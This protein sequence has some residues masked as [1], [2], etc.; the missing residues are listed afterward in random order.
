MRPDTYKAA[1]FRGIG[2]VDVVNL[3]YPVCG[4]DDIVVR[5]LLTGVCGSD[6]S[7]Y[8]HGGDSHM[9]WKD[10]EFGHESLSEV[11]EIGK[12][13]RDLKIGDHVFPNQGKALRDSKRMATVGGFSEYIRIPQCEVGYSVL[14]ID[15]DIPLKS[16]VLFEP[17]V[18]GTRG[19]RNLGPGPGKTAIV[20]GAGIIGMSTA[21][22]LQWYGC[23]KVMIVDISDFRLEKAK[24]FG[25]ITCNSA[26][27]DLKAKA[28]AE[29]GTQVGFFGE[30]CSADLYID[31]I[32]M[33]V[34]IENFTV[35]ACRDA[36]LEILGVHHE[37]VAVD[38]V[39]VC[40]SNWKIVGAGNTP[41]EVAMVDI[42]DM[43][44]SRRYDLAS[45]V[46]HEYKVDQIVDA[47]VMGSM[48]SEAQKV[49]ISF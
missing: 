29:F 16:A 2:R 48:A 27:E 38:L 24:K 10:H 45:L 46:T 14:R 26:K 31:A 3:P 17:L 1:I 42:L 35:L 41:I 12:N 13:V 47:L 36:S 19:A 8:K 20:F 44:R 15:N 11:I 23:S 25:L 39:N 34:A 40:Y 32:G 9:I 30:R 4:D 43:M 6:V 7:A 18:V 37:P 49:C 28:F 33:K 5:N 22:M 21:I